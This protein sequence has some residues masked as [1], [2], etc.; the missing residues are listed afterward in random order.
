MHLIALPFESAGLPW[1]KSDRV[2]LLVTPAHPP[3]RD[4][5][6]FPLFHKHRLVICPIRPVPRHP[7]LPRF[8]EY[9][10]IVERA[11]RKTVQTRF[12]AGPFGDLCRIN[13]RCVGRPSIPL[14]LPFARA[15]DNYR[16]HHEISQFFVIGQSRTIYWPINHCEDFSIVTL[17]LCLAVRS[18]TKSTEMRH[19]V[20]SRRVHFAVARMQP[21]VTTVYAAGPQMKSKKQIWT[22]ALLCAGVVLAG[23]AFTG[24]QV[25]V[26]GQTLPNPRI[27]W[28][29]TCNISHRVLNSNCREKPLRCEK[30]N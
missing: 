11:S 30:R 3:A 14:P 23:T 24:C 17:V 22:K 19:F 6:A 1:Q 12:G 8:S 5:T 18:G 20:G 25:T 29:T 16:S 26:G 7:G 4:P 9:P 27:T 28:T 15:T 13:N 21:N 2:D 10:R